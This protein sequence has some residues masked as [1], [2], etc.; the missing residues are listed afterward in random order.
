MLIN[1]NTKDAEANL[2]HAA[3]SDRLIGIVPKMANRHGL[4]AGATGTGKTVSLQVL[5][6]GFS[7]MGVPVF[8]ADMKGDLSGVAK[9]GKMNKFMEK[10]Q[11]E[12]GIEY[13][14]QAFPVEFFDVFKE[15]GNP[16]RVTV[17]DLGSQLLSRI[18]ELNDTQ[19]GVLTIAFRV[20]RE[21]NK[22]METLTDLRNMLTYV[23][24]H[25]AELSA[26]LGAVSTASVG[27]IQ[28]ALLR[29]EEEGGDKFL[30]GKSFNVM[31]F[32]KTKD[33][34]GVINILAADKLG[35]SPLL[36]STFLFWLLTALYENLPEVGDADKPKFVFFFDEAHLLFNDTQKAVLDKI[37]KIVRLIRSKGVGVYFITQSP[38]DI[39]EN[40]LAQL[41][42][43]IQHALRAFTPKDQRT[44]K[45]VADGFRENPAFKSEEALLELETGEALISF[46]DEKGAPTM[47]ERAKMLSPAGQIGPITDEERREFITKSSFYEK[48]TPAVKKEKVEEKAET[49]V[50]EE[51]KVEDKS[52]EVLAEVEEMVAEMQAKVDEI[53]ELKNKIAEFRATTKNADDAKDDIK[54]PLADAQK[55]KK[56]VSQMFRDVAKKVGDSSDKGLKS[57]LSKAEKLDKAAESGLDKVKKEYDT[58]RGMLTKLEAKEKK[59]KE[60]RNKT[61]LKFL[62]DLI[63]A[64]FK[65][66]KKR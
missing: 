19:E 24:E 10:R 49:K 46:L 53:T 3:F 44:I 31:D 20:S 26:T 65:G 47:V 43:K 21:Q 12:F 48:E 23:S 14:F 60:K 39:P 41:G 54:D 42:N 66:S 11:A 32:I 62:K 33:G 58:V 35:N 5:A 37:E 16:I 29:L 52:A 51:P 15:Q 7:Q 57:A 25:A 8:M 1:L 28:R 17:N 50:K 4:I 22:P 27:A 40:V 18:L 55:L 56:E 38:I 64:I 6:E 59:E 2:L 36:Y 34:K 61:I 13:G 30:C 45:S 9:E 63:L